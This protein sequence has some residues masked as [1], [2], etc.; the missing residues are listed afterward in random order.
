MSLIEII[1]KLRP[2]LEADQRI[3]ALWLEG[4]YAT[5][6]FRPD[7]DIDV[8]LDVDNDSEKE[9][10]KRFEQALNAVADIRKIEELKFYSQEPKLAKA[11][12][13]LQSFDDDNRIELDIQQHGRN[14]SFNREE[15]PIVVIFDKDQTIKWS[16]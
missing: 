2:I 16:E 6:E 3:H 14:F 7:S 5:G 10:A 11:K 4:S 13:Y 15:N 12:F 8:W 1:L 9:V